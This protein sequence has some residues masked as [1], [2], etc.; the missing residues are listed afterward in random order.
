[1]PTVSIMFLGS[2]KRVDFWQQAAF[3]GKIREHRRARLDGATASSNLRQAKLLDDLAPGYNTGD[4]GPFYTPA[5]GRFPRDGKT[6][7]PAFLLTGEKPKP[8]EDPRKALGRILP[9]HIQFA[10]AAVNIV[11]QKLMVVGLVEPYDGFDLKRLDPKNPPPAPW[12]IQPANPELLEALAED[13]RD[14]QLQHSSCH[15]DHHEIQRVSA[16]HQL[17]RRMEGRLY[18]VL[19]AA[20]CPCFDGSGSRRCLTQ[21]TDAPF[22]LKQY[23]ADRQYVKELTNPLDVSMSRRVR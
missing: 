18:S 2:K 12:T 19:C 8:G 16:F 20:V 7:Q 10:R 21:A 1:M 9:T 17:S 15:Q 5:E 13:F 3:F 11:W 23:G 6:Y 4:D 14:A 22:T